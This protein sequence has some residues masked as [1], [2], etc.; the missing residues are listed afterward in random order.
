VNFIL[1]AHSLCAFFVGHWL[2][3]R[4][5]NFWLPFRK[6]L[7]INSRLCPCIF[8]AL[9]THGKATFASIVFSANTAM[10]I[11]TF[12]TKNATSYP[13]ILIPSIRPWCHFNAI[14]F[15]FSFLMRQRA[16][17]YHVQ[18]IYPDRVQA[19]SEI[20]SSYRSRFPAVQ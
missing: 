20:S 14:F 18:H 9:A 12:L 3:R 1:A 16:V 8:L 7:I 11:Q 4:W 17:Q 19:T 13:C 5:R 15:F 2:F 6:K 10:P